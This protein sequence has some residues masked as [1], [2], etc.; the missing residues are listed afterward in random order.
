MGND[1]SVYSNGMM[2]KSHWT[3]E[4]CS[5]CLPLKYFAIRRD[6]VEKKLNFQWSIKNFNVNAWNIRSIHILFLHSFL[7]P[8][9]LEMRI[10]LNTF[11][12]RF[13]EQVLSSKLSIKQEIENILLSPR[14]NLSEFFRLKFNSVF[15]EIFAE[16]G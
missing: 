12:Y 9:M 2:K 5:W 4:I 1:L 10:R 11:S 13:A 7:L 15:E 6:Q 14:I 8:D 3:F 16:K